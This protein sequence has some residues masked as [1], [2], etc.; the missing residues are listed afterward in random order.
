M[1]S[2]RW[3]CRVVRRGQRYR[4]IVVRRC[5]VLKWSS[6]LVDRARGWDHRR[7]HR[8]RLRLLVIATT[9]S[10]EAGASASGSCHWWL[11]S[12]TLGVV[13]ILLVWNLCRGRMY[14]MVF[15]MSACHGG[16]LSVLLNA[17]ACR[18]SVSMQPS[19]IHTREGWNLRLAEVLSFS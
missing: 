6:L 13:L 14:L 7:R 10:P 5:W 2:I 3:G 19:A 9:L 16:S 1:V 12:S 18:G 15:K 17:K 8:A 11:M 4:Q